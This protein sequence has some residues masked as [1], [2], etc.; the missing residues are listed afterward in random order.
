MARTEDFEPD[1]IL[2][3]WDL[4][5]WSGEAHL[6]DLRRLDQHACIVVLCRR[7]E[8]EPVVLTAGAGAFVSKSA[9]PEQLLAAL[10]ALN[11]SELARRGKQA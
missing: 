11:W 3:D 7:P 6:A 9:S 2:L 8:I 5:G 4:P 10:Q 1:V